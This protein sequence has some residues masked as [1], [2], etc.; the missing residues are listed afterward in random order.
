MKASKQLLILA[1]SAL[2]SVSVPAL[3]ADADSSGFYLGASVGGSNFKAECSDGVSCSNP[4]TSFKLLAGYQFSP[5]WAVEGSYVDFGKIGHTFG[6]G[7]SSSKLHS[8]TLAG[9]GFLP[10]SDQA[11]LFGKLGAHHSEA[12]IEDNYYGTS[13][14]ETRSKSGAMLGVGFQY[15]FTKNFSGRV[16]YEWLNLGGGSSGSNLKLYTAGVVYK[17]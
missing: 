6:N 7:H 16:E 2:A 11:K 8:F 10:L 14:S 17:F 1:L 13:S 15:D 5:N 4:G 12:K 9:V 3:A